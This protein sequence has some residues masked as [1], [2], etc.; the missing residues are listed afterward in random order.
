MLTEK[1]SIQ[2]T[3]LGSVAFREVFRIESRLLEELRLK[4][5]QPTHET[6]IRLN[7][8]N[9]IKEQTAESNKVAYGLLI[10]VKLYEC[11]KLQ[12]RVVIK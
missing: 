10:R 4:F 8:T 6:V 1:W 9:C 3:L 11:F 7:L 2:F 5:D 12:L